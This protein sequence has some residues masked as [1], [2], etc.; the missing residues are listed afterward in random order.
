MPLISDPELFLSQ[1][2]WKQSFSPIS[3][4]TI[5]FLEAGYSTDLARISKV[6]LS[7]HH[8]CFTRLII[9]E[10][11]DSSLSD[12]FGRSTTY[13]LSAVTTLITV[14]FVGGVPFILATLVL[15]ILYWNGELRNESMLHQSQLHFP[16][17]LRKY[18]P[19]FKHVLH[20]L[21]TDI[22]RSTV[23]LHEICED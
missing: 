2:S 14:S 9:R 16:L 21:L 8:P 23:R 20:L 15:S 17:Q 12:N 10:G 5:L 3:A 11:I 6:K 4:F 1:D 18:A 22:C 19:V 13:G 7:R